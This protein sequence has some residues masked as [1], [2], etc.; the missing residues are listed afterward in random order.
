[1]DNVRLFGGGVFSTDRSCL[2]RRVIENKNLAPISLAKALLIDN[3]IT[4]TYF[5]H[6]F[7]DQIPSTLVATPEMPALALNTPKYT[8]A[9]GYEKIFQTTT[10]YAQQGRVDQLYWLSDFSQ[11]SYKVK[12]YQQL[13]QR[14]EKF[15]LPEDCSAAGV[16]IARGNTGTTR[17]L[18]NEQELIT[19]LIERGFT[20]IYPETMSPEMI[21]RSLWNAPVII[22]I[23]GSQI[24][25]TIHTISRTACVL[26]LMPPNR[27][28]HIFKGIFDAIGKIAYGFYVCTALKDTQG[29]YVDSFSDLDSLVDRLKDSAARRS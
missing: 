23:E 5:G 1:M 7:T 12:R 26:V 10:R 15:L 8:H 22:S 13:R 19:H 9:P 2:P 21:A 27:V 16:Y 29:F 20:I 6:W 25:H 3:D 28:S 4:Q 18:A 24:A 17:I 11:N 14:A